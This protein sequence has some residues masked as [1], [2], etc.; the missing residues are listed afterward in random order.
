MP[1]PKTG[2]I[3]SVRLSDAR[4]VRDGLR[5]TWGSVMKVTLTIKHSTFAVLMRS[6]GFSRSSSMII[7]GVPILMEP[8]DSI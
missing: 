8:V 4:R 2:T 6:A 3:P 7:D 1:K 5:A